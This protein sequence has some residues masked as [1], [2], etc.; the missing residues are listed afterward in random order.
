MPDT[1]AIRAKLADIVM[2]LVSDMLFDHNSSGLRFLV[3]LGGTYR[4]SYHRESIPYPV[5]S[6]LGKL[7]RHP[8]EHVHK[9]MVEG[10]P[11]CDVA[12]FRCE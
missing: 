8:E 12:R 9:V 1:A 3:N 11:V 4:Q 6:S 7:R 5:T 10:R 2:P